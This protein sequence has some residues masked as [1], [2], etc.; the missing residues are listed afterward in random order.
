MALGR[1]VAE[2]EQIGAAEYDN[3]QRYWIVEPWGAY[4]DNLHAGIVASVIAN[5]SANRRRGSTAATPADFMLKT[6]REQR[7]S[8]TAKS[9]AF[10]R[11][12][13]KRVTA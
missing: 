1:T 12:V 10:L 5:T 13:G 9:L 11:A 2:I 7:G 3:W 6:E 4:R 8:E